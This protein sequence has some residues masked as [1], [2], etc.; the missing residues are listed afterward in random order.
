MV[1]HKKTATQRKVLLE[2]FCS[3]IMLNVDSLKIADMEI[4]KTK[5]E[6]YCNKDRKSTCIRIHC[7][8]LINCIFVRHGNVVVRM[9]T[10][11]GKTSFD[12][13]V[14]HEKGTT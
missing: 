10:I 14:K 6:N 11:N 9:I 1:F 7:I 12:W 13:L 2:C 4:N 8:L 5:Q 3:P